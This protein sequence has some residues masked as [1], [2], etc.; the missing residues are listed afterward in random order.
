MAKLTQ[1]DQKHLAGI[2]SDLKRG[3]AYVMRTDRYVC[4]G[5][6]RRNSEPLAYEFSRKMDDTVLL[7]VDKEIGSELAILWT[8]IRDLQRFLEAQ[9]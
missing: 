1:K 7:S 5:V 8:G 3:Q 6:G 9:L 2:L 4:M